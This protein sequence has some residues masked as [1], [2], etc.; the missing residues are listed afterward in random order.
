MSSTSSTSSS[1]SNNALLQLS[2]LASGID[3]QSLVTQLVA[4]ERSPETQMQAQQA[5]FNSQKSAYQTIGTDLT[6]LGTDLTN[7]TA[8][9]F[10][11]SRN[12]SVS[13]NTVA[14][15]TAAT[16]TA[17]G[18]YTFNITQ[19]AT[20]AA[21]QGSAITVNPLSTTD[22]VDGVVV[23]T[24]PF[25]N[26]VTA[27]NFTVNG[28]SI[29][30]AATDTLQ[31]VLTQI[32]TATNG[33]VTAGYDSTTDEITLSS[34]NPI[35]LGSATDTSNFLQSAQLYNNGGG[36][37][38][39]MGALGA[40][41]LNGDVSNANLTT[42]IT[43]GGSGAGQF[44][45]NGVAINFNASTDSISNILARINSSAAGVTA[46]YDTAS[47][48]FL[49]TDKTGGDM[50]ISTQDVTGNFLAATGLSSGTLQRGNN[51]QYNI[52]GGGTLISQSNTIT[53]ASSGITGLSVTA[54]TTGS[55]AVTVGSDTSSIGTA[56]TTF[57]NDYNAV[58]NFI[59]A[60]V[61]TST[62]SSGNVTP[63]PLTGNMDVEDIATQL[64]QLV[65]AAPGGL[66][67]AVQSL[68]D[69][70]FVSNGNDNTLTT[71]DTTTLNAALAGNLSAIQS[72]F[73][74]STNGLA[75]TLGKYVTNTT[76]TTG[77]LAT[78]ETDLTNESDDI[79]KN[80]AALET[81]ISADQ[82]RMTAEFVAMETTINSINSQKQYLNDYFGNSTS[83]T[84]GTGSGSTQAT[85]L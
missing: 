36:T 25:A 34:S 49:L 75:A 27:G 70:G 52:N 12:A 6:K 45:I 78:T 46:T 22:N 19:M 10:F 53:S 51:L 55:V 33:A 43:D 13:D 38:T 58:Q 44:L 16:G 64:R 37:I 5:T 32:S 18:T 42:A 76:G 14:S 39:S 8:A 81:K 4:V 48:R 20:N 15:A 59:S 29:T 77:I 2:G 67:G 66:A 72:L 3:W 50:G 85:G 60:Q 28:Q 82:T 83:N 68:G 24:A 17:L 61:I 26:P 7:L 40:V 62:D 1:S 54:L 79:T 9:N 57:V 71:S 35:V 74:D 63:G 84:N 11:N 73:T 47:N 23:G 31:S 56:I 30:I 65:N 21:I 69:L 80:I 41:N